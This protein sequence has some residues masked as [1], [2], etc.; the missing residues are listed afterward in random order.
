MLNA[1]PG[2]R[3]VENP[4]GNTKT[5]VRVNVD[6]ARAGLLGVQVV[7]IDKVVRLGLAGVPAGR[8]QDL[9]G[10][11]YDVTARLARTGRA[12]PDA[13]QQLY[14]PSQTGAQVPLAQLS[15]LTLERTLP[16]IEHFDTER[17]VTVTSQVRTGFNTDRL[18]R[19]AMDSLQ[20]WTMP[21]GYRWL[22]AGEIESRQESFGGFGGAILLATVGI[23]VVLILEF[24]TFK[25]MLIVASVVPLGVV[26]GMV[27][28]FVSGYT[29][30][31][32]AMIGFVALIGIEIKNSLLLVDYTNQLREAGA[33]LDHAIEEA[34]RVRF[35]PIVLTTA[36]AIGGLL[37]LALQGSSLYSP[38]A[39]VIIGGLISSLLLSRLV[40]PVLYKLL[41]PGLAI[42]AD[43]ESVRESGA[44]SGISVLPA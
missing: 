13:L 42:H 24:K 21:N 17:S 14:V 6:R 3:D 22:A 15:S 11:A 7:D 19:S 12:T 38:L 40:T 27:G 37:P 5:N 4:L 26:G 2:T 1:I 29:L 41:P 31:F 28:L 35:L 32:T 39:I 43:P 20:A 8:I 30:S 25:S 10:E 18:T 9:D 44:V 34:G 36:T 33:D 16:R 23:L